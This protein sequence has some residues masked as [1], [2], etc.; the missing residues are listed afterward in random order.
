MRLE[1][2]SLLEDIRLAAELLRAF[3]AGKSF[4]DYAS[5]AMLRSAVERQFEIIGE[6]LGRLS[7]TDPDIADQIS[8]CRRII[9]FRNV[10]IHGYDVV[11]DAVVWDILQKNLMPMY[12]EITNLLVENSD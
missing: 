5:D 6:A 8:E 4:D 9:N 7:R 1:S 10:L 2:K 12:Q 11:D 3:T